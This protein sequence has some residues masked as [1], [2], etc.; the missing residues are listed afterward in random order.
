[1]FHDE[2]SLRIVSHKGECIEQQSDA[3]D[4]QG[5]SQDLVPE[6]RVSG[7]F[8]SGHDEGEGVAHGKE[9]EGEDQVGGGGTMPGSMCQGRVDMGPAPG[10]VDQDHEGDGGTAENIEGWIAFLHVA[11]IGCLLI[12]ALM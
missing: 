3:K 5:A 2:L 7:K 4:E 9:K 8:E 6:G 12:C 11:G 10:I 1:M